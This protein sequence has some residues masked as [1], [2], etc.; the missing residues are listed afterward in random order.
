MYDLVV[1]GAGSG[2]ITAAQFAARL[3]VKVALVEKHRIGG[4]CT[5]TGCVPSKALL[6]IAKTAHAVR[7]ASQ[8]GIETGG[9]P[10]VDMVA[11]RAAVRRAVTGVYR[12]ETP[13]KLAAEG[14][15]VLFGAAQFVDPH[16]LH[17]SEQTLTAKKFIIA[18]GAHPFIPPVPG[19][20]DVPYQTYLQ[21][22]NNQ[23]LPEHL[24][25][26]GAGPIGVELAQAYRRLGA[27]VTLVDVGLLPREEPEVA[28]VMGR[29]FAREGIEFVPGLVSEARQ[30]GG[31]TVITVAG[32]EYRGDV[33]LVAV[34]RAPNVAGLNLTQ[35]GVRATPNGIPVDDYLRT[36]V[37]HIFAAGDVIA[38]N[39][40][41]THVAGWQGYKAV[42]NALLPGNERGV[43]GVMP[44]TT[45][46]EPEVAH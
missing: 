46:T 10:R 15:E 32:Q 36:N 9:P 38:G 14:I 42:R 22:F 28:Q 18:T 19:L 33:L 12:H 43:T 3:G 30:E 5:W 6:K 17:A 37:R 31:Q 21:I 2:G 24:L 40:Q 26:M 23:H 25:V 13:E 27:R 7:T 11:V 44:W 35:A 8:V 45:F 39:Y 20:A 4:D 34:G 1:I 16:T 41:F 29:V